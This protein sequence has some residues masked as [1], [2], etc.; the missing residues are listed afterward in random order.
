MYLEVIRVKPTQRRWLP[1]GRAWNPGHGLCGF[2]L[3]WW[4]GMLVVLIHRGKRP[5]RG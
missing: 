2:T 5:R 1:I 4:T 3:C